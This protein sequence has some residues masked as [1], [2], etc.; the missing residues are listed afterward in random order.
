MAVIVQESKKCCSVGIS[1]KKIK[2][3]T[4][5]FRRIDKVHICIIIYANN[6]T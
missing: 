3:D 5:D 4:S 2:V 6:K 1:K